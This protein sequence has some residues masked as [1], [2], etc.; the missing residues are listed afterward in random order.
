[1]L[2]GLEMKP[3]L[4]CV[5]IGRIEAPDIC[6]AKVALRSK[7]CCARDARIG[8]SQYYLLDRIC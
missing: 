3:H 8:N 5:G 1:M 4:R 6:I 2:R 7:A